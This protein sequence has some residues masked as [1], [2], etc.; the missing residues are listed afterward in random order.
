M[1]NEFLIFVLCFLY[2]WL[3]GMSFVP[4]KLQY[5]F[6]KRGEVKTHSDK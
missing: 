3:L 5:F 4:V 6:G 2:V 1:A